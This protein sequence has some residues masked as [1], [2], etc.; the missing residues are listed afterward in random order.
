MKKI[1]TLICLL[2]LNL[3]AH[4]LIMNVF[5]NEDDTITVSGAFSTGQAAVGAMIRLEALNTGNTLYKSRLPEL[6]EVTID[7]PKEPYQIVLDG[8]PGHQIVKDGIAPKGGFTVTLKDT[9]KKKELSEPRSFTKK[10]SLP[11]IILISV[12]LLL[13]VL[14][15][16][17][18]MKNTQKI[19]N[20]IKENN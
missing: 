9:K 15:I 13:I 1:L 2:T 17:F 7:I 11:Y 8:G 3:Q 5:D 12:V 6:S 18:S 10:W 16:Y 19:I 4:T 14:T 20:T